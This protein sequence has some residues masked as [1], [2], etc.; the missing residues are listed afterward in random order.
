MPGMNANDV[1]P[2]R[3]DPYPNRSYA[4]VITNL[5]E[6]PTGGFSLGVGA[7]SY[8]GIFGSVMLNEKNFDIT[9][10][11]RSWS[12]LFSGNAFRG[13]GQQVSVMLMPGTLINR[14]QVSFREPY[15]FD[16]PIGL[17]TS[18]YLFNR[19]PR[20]RPVLARP[21]VRHPDLRGRRVPD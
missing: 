12:D 4:D 15:L 14:F 5:E 6:A 9:N 7:S 21:A 3:Q 10:V 18:G 1:G 13:G 16:L 2:D 11:P 17:N 8:Q 20:R 19:I